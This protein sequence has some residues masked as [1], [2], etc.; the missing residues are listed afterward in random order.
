[1]ADIFKRRIRDLP[2]EQS[3]GEHLPDAFALASC[4]GLAQVIVDLRSA[5]GVI[6]RS[7]ASLE[8][9]ADLSGRRR[10]KSVGARRTRR[11]RGPTAHR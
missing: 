5:V 4:V 6:D 7:I 3:I 10:S 2:A 1:M 9:L 8:R 11:R